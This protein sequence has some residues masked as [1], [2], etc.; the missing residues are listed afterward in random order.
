[1]TNKEDLE[2]RLKLFETGFFDAV[3]VICNSQ[4]RRIVFRR[5]DRK[6]IRAEMSEGLIELLY[7]SK[8]IHCIFAYNYKTSKTVSIRGDLLDIEITRN[9]AVFD[10]FPTNFISMLRSVEP[11]MDDL[12]DICPFSVIRDIDGE[13]LT[14]EERKLKQ[15]RRIERAARECE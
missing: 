7:D 11:L 14:E 6:N 1:M 5:G 12:I 8:E 13:Y 4:Y 9:R 15:I 2:L 3:Q 10:C